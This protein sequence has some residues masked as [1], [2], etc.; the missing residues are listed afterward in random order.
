MQINRI[1]FKSQVISE[2]KKFQKSSNFRN[3]EISKINQFQ[4]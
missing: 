3:Q 1:N 4:K 2:I